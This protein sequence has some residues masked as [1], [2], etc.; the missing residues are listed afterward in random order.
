MVPKT[1][2]LTH[3]VI[4]LIYI[5]AVHGVLKA[6][7]LK[8]FANPFSSGSRINILNL[9]FWYFLKLFSPMLFYIIIIIV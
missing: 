8:W 5:H 7:T 9:V 2:R 1:K 3:N 6:R 4:I